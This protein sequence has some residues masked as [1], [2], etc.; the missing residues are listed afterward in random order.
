MM[1]RLLTVLS[2]MVGGLLTA[3]AQTDMTSKLVNPSFENGFNGWMQTGMQT[4]DNTVF[5]LKDGNVYAEKWVA[6]GSAVGDGS[7]TQVVKGLECGRYRLTAAA[8]NIQEDTPAATKT[9]AWLVGESQ[10]TAVGVRAEYSVTFVVVT[11]DATIG[12]M[13]ERAQG[14]WIAVDH[15]RLEYIDVAAEEQQAEPTP[16]RQRHRASMILAD[17]K[18]VP[19]T[20]CATCPPAYMWSADARSSSDSRLICIKG[21]SVMSKISA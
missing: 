7:V 12:F 3:F 20:T 11:G 4:Q 15:F 13:A 2:F 17:V 6:R 1:K 19:P 10:R 9:G 18:S 5:T 16:K 21:V 8:Q 14:N